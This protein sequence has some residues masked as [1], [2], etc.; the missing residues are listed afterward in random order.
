MVYDHPF[1][2]GNG[3]TARALFYWSM[4]RQ[5]YWLFEFI[6]ISEI[7][8]NAPAQYA[9]A[10]LYAETDQNDLTYFIV[11]HA[12][13]IKK[14]IRSLHDYINRKTSEL[15][16]VEDLINK[17]GD[18]NYRQESLLAHALRHPGAVYTIEAH[19]NAHQIAYDRARHDLQHLHEKGLLSML[20]KGKT[21]LFT[22]PKP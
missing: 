2:D 14:S 12:D 17:Y 1:V 11:H 16:E 4:L 7:I 18:F 13:V 6:S 3:R 9:E 20:K 15:N 10:F 19:K 5:G 22:A 21:Y 8:L